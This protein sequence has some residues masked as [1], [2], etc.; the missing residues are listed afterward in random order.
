MKILKNSVIKASKYSL[1]L[2]A[3]DLLYEEAIC[4]R[5]LGMHFDKDGRLYVA[6]AYYG[7]FK[8]DIKTGWWVTKMLFYTV[9]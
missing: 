6:D 4:G 8:V 1:Q 7:L 9:L 5:P 3:E 2:I